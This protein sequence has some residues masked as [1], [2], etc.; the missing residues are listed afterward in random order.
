MTLSDL[1]TNPD[2]PVNSYTSTKYFSTGKI[3]EILNTPNYK[4]QECCES[5]SI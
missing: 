1:V 5:K 4:E 2:L 3:Q